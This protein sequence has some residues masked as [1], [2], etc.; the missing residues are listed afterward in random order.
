LPI[1]NG[2]RENA[3]EYA[4]HGGDEYELL[5][6]ARPNAPIPK[7]IAGVE[8]TPIGEVVRGNKMSLAQADGTTEQLLVKGWEHFKAVASG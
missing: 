3:L 4:L 8:I 1:A 5:F 7:R 2:L 6:T